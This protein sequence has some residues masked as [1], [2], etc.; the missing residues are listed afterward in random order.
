VTES[1]PMDGVEILIP[2]GIRDRRKVAMRES[3]MDFGALIDAL[4]T[5]APSPL[6]GVLAAAL[7]DADMDTCR[8][9]LTRAIRALPTQNDMTVEVFDGTF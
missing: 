2:K 9:W 3:C 4:P 1:S 6:D 7:A 8:A 5:T